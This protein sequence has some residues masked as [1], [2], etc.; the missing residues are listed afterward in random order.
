MTECDT[1]AI[2]VGPQQLKIIHILLHFAG[3]LDKVFSAWEKNLSTLCKLG[4]SHFQEF[5]WW[6]N[7]VF[8]C[9]IAAEMQIG[10][11]E[12]SGAVVLLI[13]DFQDILIFS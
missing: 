5:L 11:G 2:I 9:V 8:G 4:E 1:I 13:W 6:L 10:K 7:E 3:R 12:K